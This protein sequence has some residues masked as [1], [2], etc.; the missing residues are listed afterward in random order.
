MIDHF[1]T[2]IIPFMLQYT[3]LSF[4]TQDTSSG[5][6]VGANRAVHLIGD[7]RDLRLT[8]HRPD[9]LP[10]AQFEAALAIAQ[11]LLCLGQ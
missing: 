8:M 11:V 5:P 6:S 7:L 1:R 4:K 10:A 9:H 3:F 2:K